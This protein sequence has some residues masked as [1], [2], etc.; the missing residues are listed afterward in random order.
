LERVLEE[1]RRLRQE[2]L[3]DL[4]Q[5]CG[6]MRAKLGKLNM[7]LY[8]SYARG[9]FNVWSDIDILI[10]SEAF[11]GI[12]FLDRYNLI[13]EWIKPGWEPKAYTPKEFHTMMTKP[14]WKEALRDH[15]IICDELG[16][17]IPL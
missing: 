5:A 4:A 14:S 3:V 9:D 16:L 17:N 15:V 6:Q 7:I 8:G 10:I 11:E 2:V 12:R 13:E 1:R